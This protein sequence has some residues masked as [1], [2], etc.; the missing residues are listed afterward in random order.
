[1]HELI[2]LEK[3]NRGIRNYSV[4]VMK[5]G[6][7]IRFLHKITEG[8]TDNSYGIEVAKL[9]GLPPKVIEE[10]KLALKSMEHGSKID[11]EKKLRE[12]EETRDQ[13]D[14]SSINKNAVIQ[15]IRG[16]DLDDLTPREAYA[17]L[18]ELKNMLG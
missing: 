7:D 2:A 6:D 5:K 17:K 16:L 3:E 1:Y 10:A 8:G 14:F 18:E 15:A 4:S 9:A 12:E 11:L 13:V